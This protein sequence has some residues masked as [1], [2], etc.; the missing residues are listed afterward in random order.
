MKLKEIAPFGR[1]VLVKAPIIIIDNGDLQQE[2][3]SNEATVV[4]SSI[5]EIKAKDT[6]FYV[7]YG[8]V[9][10]TKL[11]TK[12]AFYLIVDEEEIYGIEQ[13]QKK[14]RKDRK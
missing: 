3:P 6:V 11:K 12:K 8:A 10:I 5:D 7:P 4:A 9:E 14:V 1:R 13:A 2:Q